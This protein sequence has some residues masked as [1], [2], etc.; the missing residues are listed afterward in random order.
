MNPAMRHH[1]CRGLDLGALT[2][3]GSALSLLLILLPRGSALSVARRWFAIPAAGRQLPDSFTR[4]L[5]AI[6]RHALICAVDN[7]LRCASCWPLLLGL[8]LGSLLWL[9]GA[10]HA[11]PPPLVHNVALAWTKIIETP[12]MA[13]KKAGQHCCTGARPNGH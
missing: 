12:L 13:A 7:P 6:V 3:G 5:V 11:A 9:H 10:A 8:L 1:H 2:M 4:Q